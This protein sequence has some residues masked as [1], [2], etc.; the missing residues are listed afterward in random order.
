VLLAGT[1]DHLVLTKARTL[2]YRQEPRD[3]FFRPSVDV[4]FESVADYWPQT[5]TAV[6]LTGMGRDGLEGCRQ[7]AARGGLIVAE[8]ASSC[9]VYGM[10]KAVIEAGLADETVPLEQMAARLEKR[11]REG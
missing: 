8:A 9:V 3:V 2:E 1:N 6:L 5:G 11:L 7:L 4:F 10:P